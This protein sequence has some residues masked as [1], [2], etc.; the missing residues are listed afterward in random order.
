MVAAMASATLTLPLPQPKHQHHLQPKAHTTHSITYPKQKN[1]SLL[2][3]T[4]YPS[5]KDSLCNPN[6][7]TD[8]HNTC[9]HYAS[10]LQA[11]VETQSL[12]Y[13]RQLHARVLIAGLQQDLLVATKIINMYAVCSHLTEALKVFESIDIGYRNIFLWNGLIKGYVKNEQFEEAIEFYCRMQ[14]DAFNVQPDHYTFSCLLKAC[15]GSHALQLGI[16]IHLNIIR[17][18][19]PQRDAVSWNTIIAG[20]VQKG[21]AASTIFLFQRIRRRADSFWDQSPSESNR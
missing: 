18:G 17:S 14:R 1:P 11:C 20:Y 3:A 15:A 5:L 16:Q 8:N 13:G 19:M 10:L 12:T 6:F 9:T 7:E 21:G 4:Q 2:T